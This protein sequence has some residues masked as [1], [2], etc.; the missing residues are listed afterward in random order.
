MKKK[1]GSYVQLALI[2]REGRI[3]SNEVLNGMNGGRIA[4]WKNL[5]VTEQMPHEKS[6][7]L[8]VMTCGR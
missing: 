2:P 3:M 7:P 8:R 5:T 1:A 6:Y 4:S